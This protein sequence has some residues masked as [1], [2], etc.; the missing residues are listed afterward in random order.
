MDSFEANTNSISSNSISSN[1]N[2]A[3]IQKAAELCI[4][5]LPL[6]NLEGSPQ[7]IDTVSLPTTTSTTTSDTITPVPNLTMPPRRTNMATF[8]A[9]QSSETFD[10]KTIDILQNVPIRSVWMATLKRQGIF[11]SIKF[12]RT[13]IDRLEEVGL[14]TV[15][16]L[17]KVGTGRSIRLLHEKLLH[18]IGGAPKYLN[19]IQY[20]RKDVF[21]IQ[22]SDI[23]TAVEQYHRRAS[24][25][26]PKLLDQPSTS[27]SLER[28][29]QD[30]NPGGSEKSNTTFNDVQPM[31]GQP[32]TAETG[33]AL[34]E[35]E[36]IN[37]I[38]GCRRSTRNNRPRYSIDNE[39]G[40]TDEDEAYFISRNNEASNAG[41]QAPNQAPDNEE[42]VE[43]GLLP[44]K[45]RYTTSGTQRVKRA[46]TS[47]KTLRGPSKGRGTVKI[48]SN[49][50]SGGRGRLS[51]RSNDVNRA[52]TTLGKPLGN[53]K[54]SLPTAVTGENTTPS[55]EQGQ[56][57]QPGDTINSLDILTE[58]RN[59][60][61]LAKTHLDQRKTA[62]KRAASL[63]KIREDEKIEKLTQE[64]KEVKE[65]LQEVMGT[66][67]LLF[68][69]CK[70]E[71]L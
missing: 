30:Q 6:Q 64:M 34:E 10:Q 53:P 12:K 21:S 70:G 62:D 25:D 33:E 47:N 15:G 66:M 8:S 14:G 71:E 35:L 22:E 27:E 26:S 36:A 2:S 1:P 49:G 29:S 68:A 28:Q 23:K 52:S 17:V 4:P 50:S 38:W 24:M 67:K 37:R 5:E 55:L 51:S 19:R 41:S 13:W 3:Q 58:S 48:R 20:C 32:N 56:S 61:S 40:S 65:T 42:P 43:D 69:F 31:L 44:R 16:A 63:E 59:L 7:S 11:S 46:K 60:L 54:T 9:P 57:I 45:R 18:G 39:V